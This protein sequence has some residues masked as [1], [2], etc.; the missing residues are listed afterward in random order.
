MAATASWH[1]MTAY[2]DHGRVVGFSFGPGHDPLVRT[3]TGLTL[4][5]TLSRAR[6][7]YGKRLTDS[8]AQGGVWFAATTTG[9]IDGFLTPSTGRTPTG[10]DRIET[11]D[12]GVV[13]CPAMSP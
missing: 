2:F 4:G 7:L 1:A 10:A 11:I 6:A 3:A 12:V 5:D 13:G 8:N 9:R